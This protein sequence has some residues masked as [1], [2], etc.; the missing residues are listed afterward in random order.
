MV[1]QCQIIINGLRYPKELL[2]LAGKDG[3]VGKLLNGIHRIITANVDKCINIQLVQD[4]ENLLINIS[5]FM[6][7]RKLVPA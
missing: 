6:Y 7:F 3:I 2:G 1:C 4:L 5:V